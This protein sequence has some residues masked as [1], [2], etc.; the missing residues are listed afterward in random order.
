MTLTAK[1][2]DLPEITKKAFD[3]MHENGV[4][5]GLATGREL[6]D[7]LYNQGAEWG[8]S[9]PMDFLIGMNGGMLWDRFHG[10]VWNMDLMS[11][12]TMKEILYFM[13]PI[14]DEYE[15]SVN[16]EGGGNH[17]AMHIKGELFASMK[18]RGWKFDDFTGDIDGFCERPAYKFL[19]RSTPENED[20][21]RQTF[22]QRFGDEYQI[23]GTFPGT[24]EAMRR[25]IDKGSGMKRYADKRGIPMENIIAFGD[26]ENDNSLL[27]ACGWGVALKN[28]TD[29]TK[30]IADD[31]TEY[32]CENSGVGHY[33]F[34][35]YL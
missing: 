35:H 17:A 24:V 13:K 19:F 11:M 27:I 2:G 25:G 16:V 3:A 34:D 18:R 8:L 10:N 12:D 7:R 4:L 33:L 22:L 1:G 5:I 32:D 9:Y 23:I 14:V 21:I 15:V 29:A 30:A 20:E 6:N 26:N 28:A 31:V